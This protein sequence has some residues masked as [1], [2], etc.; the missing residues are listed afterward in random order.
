MSGNEKLERELE[1]FLKDDDSR[2]AR[3]YRK[4]PRPEPDAG[5][6]AA[7]LAMARR[8]IAG[9]EPVPTTRRTARPRWVPVFSVAAVIALAAGI[10]Y[11]LGPQMW[12][13]RKVR[14]SPP[15]AHATDETRRA[16]VPAEETEG[17]RRDAPVSVSAPSASAGM[18]AIQPQPL[19]SP[20]EQPVAKAARVQSPPS[21]ADRKTENGAVSQAQ[22]FP[23]QAARGSTANANAGA[24]TLR[25][26]QAADADLAKQ[27][28]SPEP[29]DRAAGAPAQ[30]A[31][32][33][34]PAAPQAFG[35]MITQHDAVGPKEKRARDPNADL[36]P[37]HWLESIHQMLHDGRRDDALQ[38]LA[39]FRKRY[40]DYHLPDDLRDLK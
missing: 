24:Q 16:A 31:A 21:S 4:L 13:E 37:E 10:S 5:L 9:A 17:K 14:S 23:A 25:V 29:A 34:P 39:E 1:S 7:V 20:R 33:P 40:P 6:D 8:A 35:G 18:Q 22:A 11:Q 2:V 27:A 3:L 36:Y 38:S 19:P 12:A 15:A 30:A 26:E 28:S 32:V